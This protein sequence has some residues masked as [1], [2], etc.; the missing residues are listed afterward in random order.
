MTR[1][2]SRVLLVVVSLG[3]VIHWA[4]HFFLIGSLTFDCMSRTRFIEASTIMLQAAVIFFNV[5]GLSKIISLIYFC[6][7]KI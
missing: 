3:N 2:I 4:P 5:L 6:L 1:I 7:P